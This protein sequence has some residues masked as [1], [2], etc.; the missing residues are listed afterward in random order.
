V[1]EESGTGLCIGIRRE[2]E[3]RTGRPNSR[4]NWLLRKIADV[5]GD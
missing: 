1:G 5:V 4:V 3:G 2:E